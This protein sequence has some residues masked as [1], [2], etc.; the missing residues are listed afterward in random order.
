MKSCYLNATFPELPGS[1]CHQESRGQG[2]TKKVAISRAVGAL[3]K[4]VGRC[5]W[6][7][8]QMVATVIDLPAAEEKE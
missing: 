8:I 5:K 7:T 3:L 2:S 6:G 1:R 4:K